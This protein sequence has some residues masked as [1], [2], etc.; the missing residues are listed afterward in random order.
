MSNCDDVTK[1]CVD[2]NNS[3]STKKLFNLFAYYEQDIKQQQ[4]ISIRP[5]IKII[6]KLQ[7]AIEFLIASQV[8]CRFYV[9]A[10]TSIDYYYIARVGP[11]WQNYRLFQ[12]K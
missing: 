2:T 11:T 10:T 5:D 9:K 3:E 8:P 7:I 1:V 6:Y 4:S 12:V